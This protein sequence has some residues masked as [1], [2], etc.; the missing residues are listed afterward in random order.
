MNPETRPELE[1][2]FKSIQTFESLQMAADNREKM[3]RY[4]DALMQ[5]LYSILEDQEAN[6]QTKL[7][8]LDDTLSQYAAAMKELFPKIISKP[9]RKSEAADQF[10]EIVEVGKFNPY[11][12]ELG[13][14]STANRYDQF[15]ITTRDPS[16]QHWA[17]A[18]IA[19]E[20]DRDARGLIPGPKIKPGTLPEDLPKDK[21]EETP[22]PN[23][24]APE[25]TT[26]KTILPEKVLKTCQDVEAKSV[27][28]KNE[29]LTL[30]NENG[31]IIHEKRGGKSSVSIDDDVAAKMGADV[32]LTHNHPGE[33]GGTFSGADVNVLTKYNLKGIRAVGVEG[34][35]SLERK[36]N[37]TGL[38]ASY[39]QR[40]YINLANDASRRLNAEYN[41]LKRK[42]GR[43]EVTVAEANKQLAEFR[44]KE[45]NQMHDWLAKHAS[46]YGFNYVFTPS[47]GGVSKMFDIEKED[48]V[49]EITGEIMLDG[50][51][52][53]GD[54]WMIKESDFDE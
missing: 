16:K 49:E 12:D 9:V 33:F 48:E 7:K 43:G 36:S 46:A 50:E 31:D 17:D 24:P 42:A 23:L 5:S 37:T 54:N 1:Q 35:Y 53:S 38:K 6:E 10:D 45:C 39:L 21:P 29:K 4:N 40:E 11:H 30:V 28:L 51:F 44:N 47:S 20:K 27:K 14:F 52:I 8:F 18:A 15:T 19:R 25:A 26:T 41:S 34:T 3:Y 22:K 2:L 13:R 32:T